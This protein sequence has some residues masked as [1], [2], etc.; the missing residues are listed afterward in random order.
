MIHV[1][2]LE[3]DKNS[4]EA[5]AAI[6]SAYSAELCIHP[7]ASYE[8]AKKLLET[9]IRYG[10]FLLDVN[11]SGESREDIG[12]I[13][14]AREVRERFCYTFTPIVMVTAVGEMEM[15]AYRE[16]HCYQYLMKPFRRRQVEEIVEKLLVEE[17]RE[18]PP[19][20]TVKK[21]GINYQIECADIQYIE[22]VHRGICIHMKKENWNV[23]YVTLK[24]ILGK[25]PE[26]MFVQCHRMYAV[27]RQEVEYYDTVNRIVKLKGCSDTVEIGV[28]Y[29]AEIGR[30]ISGRLG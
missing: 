8:E 18:R 10:L 23:P 27:N 28:T 25:L 14:F 24:Q 2:V 16:L 29:K 13:I 12:G 15:Q 4:R 9:D 1:L 20:V 6:L 26:E 19:V 22:A 11:L 7:A 17:K 3:D 21:G 5:V 30:V